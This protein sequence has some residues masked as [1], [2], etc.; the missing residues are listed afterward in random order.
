MMSAPTTYPKRR[1]LLRLVPVDAAA[2]PASE[3]VATPVV[4]EE[5]ERMAAQIRALQAANA[6]LQKENTEL[7]ALALVDPLTH[8]YNRRGLET[9]M[10]KALSIGQRKRTPVALLLI[11]LDGMKYVN[12]RYGHPEGDRVLRAVG[13]VLSRSVRT[14]DSAARLGGDEFAVVM[15]AT[16]RAG[17]Q[18]VAERIRAAIADLGL[19]GITA[20]VGLATFTGASA[21]PGV[22]KMTSLVGA[23]DAALYQAKRTGKN[24]VV[25]T[26]EP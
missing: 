25:A 18:V 3:P 19:S 17:A 9:E 2:A 23:A 21:E 10:E 5:T 7:R 14:S 24:R 6:R 8:L 20:S 1:S 13:E 22:D 4:D 15:P 26:P 12:D 16:D 11:D